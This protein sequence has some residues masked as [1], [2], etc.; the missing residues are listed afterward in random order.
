M[1]GEIHYL[2]IKNEENDHE[3]INWSDLIYCLHKLF[4]ENWQNFVD[5]QLF[6][7]EKLIQADWQFSSGLEKK[8]RVWLIDCIG[9]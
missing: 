4:D 2:E 3:F 1:L 7:Y 8:A 6:P 9:V 5:T